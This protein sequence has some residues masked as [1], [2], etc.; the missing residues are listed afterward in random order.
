MGKPTLFLAAG[1]G[2]TDKGNTT[3]AYV[4]RDELIVIVDHMVKWLSGYGVPTGV[5]GY[6]KI[7][8]SHAL[9][10]EIAAITGWKPDGADL[11]LD[12]HLDYRT[13]SSGALVIVD[14]TPIA[15]R[16][17]ERWLPRWCARTGIKNNGIHDSIDWATRQRGW[18][19]MGF[20]APR[21][22]GAILELGCLNAPH[23]MSIVRNDQMRYLCAQLVWETWESLR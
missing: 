1:H 8:H 20:C 2:G 9:S 7:D 10:G 11:A 15:R 5:G 4:E 22:P 12:V 17:A 13:G 18:S 14:Q 16:F 19:D 21:W 3:T 6:V 23:D